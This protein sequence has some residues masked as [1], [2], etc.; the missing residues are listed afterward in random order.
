MG[1]TL[2]ITGGATTNH[3]YRIIEALIAAAGGP[4]EK[5]ALVVSASGDGPDET[6]REYQQDFAKLGVAPE[7][8]VLVPLYDP[9]VLDEH[10]FNAINGDHPCL[11]ALLE[12]VRGVWFTGG[13][14]YYTAKC[15]LRPDGSHTKALELLH[16]IYNS[17]GAIGG[18][19]A[20]AAIMSQVMIGD[21]T[22]RA[23]LG[24]QTLYN[25]DTYDEVCAADDPINPLIIT[26]GLGFFPHGVVDQHFN[27][28]PRLLRLIEACML[29]PQGQRMGY[30]VSEDTCMICH[31]DGRVQVLGG[32]GVY[33]ADCRRAVRHGAGSY[34]GVV[35]H[36][37]HEGDTYN[38]ATGLF[39]LA[40]DD[41]GKKPTYVTADYVAGGFVDS[42]AFDHF[43]AINFLR[44]RRDLMPADTA[45]GRPYAR[46]V[47]VF[48]IDGQAWA[49]VFRYYRGDDVKG[50]RKDCHT[51]FINVEL[52]TKSQ[53]IALE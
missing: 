52:D 15:F 24:R 50:Y 2:F 42:P 39:T 53:K 37:V 47:D 3:F 18:S 1:G 27:V 6:H 46:G 4:G 19:S 17:G 10:G 21:G 25:Y 29:N 11:P 5:F 33:I 40:G 26:Q 48:D 34:S 23:V 45:S 36:A 7:N 30:A 16:Q 35:F 38:I 41:G 49:T 20:G 13:D 12:G 32:N 14:Q 8:L 22:N 43:M 28:R 51:S 44:C 31:S 9:Q